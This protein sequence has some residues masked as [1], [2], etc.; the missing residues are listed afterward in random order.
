MAR[1]FPAPLK[2]IDAVAAAVA[3]PFEEG[4]R[5]ERELFVQLA[6][7]ARNRARCGM[8]FSPSARPAKIPDIPSGTAPR[9]I[10]AGR[11]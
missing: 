3:M 9:A 6:Q 10:N 7:T 11:R 8:H 5:Y 1:G 2:C 4:L